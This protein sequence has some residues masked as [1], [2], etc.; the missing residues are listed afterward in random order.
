MKIISW[1]MA[2]RKESW[3]HFLNSN[4][5]IA[6]L[7]E[8]A[9]PP[10]DVR[11]KI[12]TDNQPWVTLSNGKKTPWR[13]AIVGLSEQ[14]QI[15]WIES[16]PIGHAKSGQLEV[17]RPGTLAA[18]K[19]TYEDDLPLILISMYGFWERTHHL[20]GGN[21]IYA[22]AS[23]HRLISDLSAFVGSQSNH[24]IIA[25]GDLNILFGYGE[26]GNSYWA[27]R[28]MTV[29]SRIESLGLKFI[30]PQSPNGRQADPWPSELPNN[31]KNIPTFH[32]T[33]QTPET[34]SRQLDFVFVSKNLG[35]EVSVTA[36]NHPD[37]W[38]PSDHCQIQ[39]T[40]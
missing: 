14:V 35:N 31:S 2:H 37:R 8:A 25:S 27:S 15:E 5:D 24:R 4:S 9:E 23:V 10:V 17:S 11:Q 1:N 36:L 13:A 30:G 16:F 32:S 7:Q 29:F 28:Y 20:V 39:I 19:V 18:A 40:V 34:A 3:S 12:V 6:L 22:D 38:G 21:K 26:R 33:H